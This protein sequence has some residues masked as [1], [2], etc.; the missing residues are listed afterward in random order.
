MWWLI[1]NEC[2]SLKSYIVIN[3][4]YNSWWLINWISLTLSHYSFCLVCV[5]IY[6]RYSFTLACQ[7]NWLIYC[8][9]ASTNVCI[10]HIW[11]NNYSWTRCIN[12]WVNIWVILDIRW[13]LGSNTIINTGSR[14]RWWWRSLNLRSRIIYYLLQN[15]LI[16][17]V[18]NI[19]LLWFYYWSYLRA[20]ILLFVLF[21]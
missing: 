4:I 14:L 17:I 12:N 11:R 6:I 3:W 1:T 18:L 19:V 9:A 13:V 2:V 20:L 10:I 21:Y 16:W 8:W 15:K 7:P 5:W